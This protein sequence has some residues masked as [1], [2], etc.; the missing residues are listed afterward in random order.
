MQVDFICASKN[1]STNAPS[2]HA[3]LAKGALHMHT[4]WGI[5]CRYIWTADYAIIM[6]VHIEFS[7]QA[8][9]SWPIRIIADSEYN[10]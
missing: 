7:K 5:I 3:I 8:G 1:A 4:A 10:V 2:A 9:G 6:P